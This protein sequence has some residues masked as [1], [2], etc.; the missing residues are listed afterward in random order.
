MHEI[1]TW[2]Y[3]RSVEAGV[4]SVMCS[5]NQLNGTWA[6]EDEYALTT[7]LKGEYGFRGFVQS[8]WGAQMSG[9]KSANAG[10]DMTMPVSGIEQIRKQT[11]NLIIT[12]IG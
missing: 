1:W 5:Y 7:L 10:L 12:C 2:P 4:G 9:A 6:C 8:D 3:A 11:A